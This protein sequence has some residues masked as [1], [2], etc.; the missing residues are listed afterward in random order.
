MSEYDDYVKKLAEELAA[1]IANDEAKQRRIN[2]A[3]IKHNKCNAHLYHYIKQEPE[4]KT[5]RYIYRCERPK[6]RHYATT[7]DIISREAMCREC[8]YPFEVSRVHIL[9]NSYADTDNEKYFEYLDCG[10]KQRARD[11]ETIR[12][13]KEAEELKI[14]EKKKLEKDSDILPEE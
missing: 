2:N 3:I 10:C 14:Q 11:K 5:S 4:S 9:K 6:C 13:A 12:E 8:G 7:G 1:K